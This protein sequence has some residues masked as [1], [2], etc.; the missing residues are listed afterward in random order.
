MKIT[1]DSEADS[2]FIYF[3]EISPGEVDKTISLNEF[4][5]IDLDKDGRT[6]GIEILEASKNLPQ[7]A[8]KSAEIIK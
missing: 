6:L 2:A 8:I 3:K 1:F 7:N 4:I 5:N